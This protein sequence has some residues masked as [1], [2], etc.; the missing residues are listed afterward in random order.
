MLGAQYV[1][2]QA[3]VVALSR[4]SQVLGDQDRDDK[5]V[6]CNDTRHNDGD[7]ALYRFEIYP[8]APVQQSIPV[9]GFVS[10]MRGRRRTFMIRSGRKVPTPAIPMPDF[11]V[12]YAA[13]A[14]IHPRYILSAFLRHSKLHG[15]KGGWGCPVR[16]QCNREGRRKVSSYIQISWLPQF[17]PVH[18]RKVSVIPMNPSR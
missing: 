13:P 1:L 11:A 9:K 17:R 8:S 2:E 4:G 10:W 16:R 5:S 7:E 3:V 18:E 14:P 15:E 6:D 12:P